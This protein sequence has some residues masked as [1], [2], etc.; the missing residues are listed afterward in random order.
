MLTCKKKSH[1]NFFITGHQLL[2]W[3]KLNKMKRLY[4]HLI[5]GIQMAMNVGCRV[6][7]VIDIQAMIK[8]GYKFYYSLNNVWLSN[9]IDYKHVLDIIYFK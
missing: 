9:D 4:V 2:I 3:I 5:K 8:D 6:V 1:H 7:L